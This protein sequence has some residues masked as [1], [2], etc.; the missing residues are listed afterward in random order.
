MVVTL[1][2]IPSMWESQNDK[3]QKKCFWSQI[4]VFDFEETTEI[5]IVKKLK[6]S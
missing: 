4:V 6:K 2:G 5:R 1:F 3:F